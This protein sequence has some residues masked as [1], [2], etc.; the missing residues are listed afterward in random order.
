VKHLVISILI[1]LFAGSA[2]ASTFVGN[3][4]NA[5]DIEL[6][7]SKREIQDT[8]RILLAQSPGE[9]NFLCTCNAML[10]GHGVCDLLKQLTP[11]QQQQ[12]AKFLKD[13]GS[14]L[15][16]A[17]ETSRIS[18]SQDN[19]LVHEGPAW[20][21]VDAVTN[22]DE[23]KI[24]LSHSRFMAMKDYER[25]FLL[26]HELG[27]L[28]TMDGKP[29]SDDQEVEHFK[30]ADGGRKF[31]NAVG[32][33]LAM[34][35]SDNDVLLSY[36]GAVKRSRG[37]SSAW[38]EVAG[39]S[40]RMS[41]DESFVVNKKAGSSLRLRYQIWENLGIWAQYMRQE[42]NVDILSQTHGKEIDSAFAAGASYRIFPFKDP[43]SFWGQSHAV[44]SIGLEQM[45]AK[46]ELS[47]SFLSAD[48]EGKSTALA[49]DLGYHFPLQSGFWIFARYGLR[50]HKYQI[51]LPYKTI[52]MK[53]TMSTEIGVSYGF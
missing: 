16:T 11:P 7:A 12:C 5:G 50:N 23:K 25:V 34:L 6:A 2:W 53:P 8:L 13:N 1:G 19:I 39:G 42:G 49:A 43:L 4:G 48:A 52:E 21:D 35:A 17:L 40:Q 30:G 10:E 28:L 3:G 33:G 36:Q 22:Y 18:W 24:T 32:A 44:L 31:L 20:R 51:E 41:T 45:T 46:Y 26:G 37:H 47:D 29:I 15:A 9:S 14:R 27:H 38:I